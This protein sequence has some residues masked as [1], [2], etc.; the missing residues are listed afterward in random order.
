MCICDLCGM[1]V[2]FAFSLQHHCYLSQK[3]TK[4]CEVQPVA[5]WQEMSKKL[6]QSQFE[7]WPQTEIWEQEFHFLLQ[8][9]AREYPVEKCLPG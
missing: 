3:H 6:Q 9:A 4:E 2:E 1:P 5:S 8:I 7:V